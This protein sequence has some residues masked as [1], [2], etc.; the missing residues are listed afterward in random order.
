[1]S[2]ELQCIK[3]GFKST[4]K[5]LLTCPHHSPYYS[6]LEPI[7]NLREFK[8]KQNNSTSLIALKDYSNS[9]QNIFAKCEYENPT[10]SVKD[11]EVSAIFQFAKQKRINAVSMVSTGSGAKSASFF[12]KRHNIHCKCYVSKNFDPNFAKFVQQNQT[13]IITK[14]GTY[15]EIFKD[16]IDND[17][18]YNITPGINPFAT[19]GMKSLISELKTQITSID[20]IIAP[21][22]NGTLLAGLWTGIKKFYP[23]NPP[24]LI[25]VE[26]EGCDPINQAIIKKQDYIILKN[27]PKTQAKAIAA[28]ESFCSPKA[29]QAI[30]ESKGSIITITEN[31]LQNEVK[32]VQ[33][34]QKITPRISSVS[35]LAALKKHKEKGNIICIISG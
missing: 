35:V 18:H 5:L 27:I 26:I 16:V 28:Q 11:R 34:T 13:E 12:S 6:Y 15:E 30:Q 20:T 8:I 1:M 31:E 2:Y 29:I 21:M 22:R 25:A 10:G 17:T 32:F 24:K 14:N 4:N 33:N 9:T 19:L 3:C 7:G 23:T